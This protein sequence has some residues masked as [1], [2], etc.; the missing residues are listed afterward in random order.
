MALSSALAHSRRS[1]Q[2]RSR[3]D[4]SGRTIGFRVRSPGTLGTDE[5]RIS[6]RF[7]QSIRP[8]ARRASE[9][10]K[11]RT[12]RQTQRG[13]A[14]ALRAGDYL[15]RVSSELFG[16]ERLSPMKSHEVVITHTL[17]SRDEEFLNEFLELGWR[18]MVFK[19]ERSG[20]EHSFIERVD[21]VLGATTKIAHPDRYLAQKKK[22]K[23][24]R[25]SGV[26]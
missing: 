3:S 6:R 15:P 19:K 13:R 14:S 23:E 26:F 18:I 20:D 4:C 17:D 11:S 5:D 9:A 2:A 25:E 16:K 7:A 12:H 8:R 22:E 1:A 24:D 10:A 21:Y